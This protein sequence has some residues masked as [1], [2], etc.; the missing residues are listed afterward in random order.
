MYG[1]DVE[2]Q[3]DVSYPNDACEKPDADLEACGIDLNRPGHPAPPGPLL[4]R[5]EPSDPDDP[6]GGV[7]PPD[8]SRD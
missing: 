5:S 7:L 2:R 8:L 1:P 4:E 6:N 3:A